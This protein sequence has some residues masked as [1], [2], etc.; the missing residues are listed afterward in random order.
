MASS[1][2]VVPALTEGGRR[3]GGGLF[4][5]TRR[6]D[7]RRLDAALSQGS[8]KPAL[9]FLATVPRTTQRRYLGFRADEHRDLCAGRV[10]HGVRMCDA[11]SF[12]RVLQPEDRQRRDLSLGT[13]RA[14]RNFIFPGVHASRGKRVAVC[15]WS[16]AFLT[17]LSGQHLWRRFDYWGYCLGLFLMGHAQGL[18]C[19]PEALSSHV[20]SFFIVSVAFVPVAPAYWHMRISSLTRISY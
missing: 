9:N 16:V 17:L 20:C 18:F 15:A 8:S 5:W 14:R 11:A 10:T 4:C 7:A 19:S 6:L 13:L 2:C 1:R 3:K 12:S